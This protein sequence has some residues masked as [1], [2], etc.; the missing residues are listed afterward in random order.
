VI[1][2]TEPACQTVTVTNGLTTT[3]QGNFTQRGFL[4][5]LTTAGTPAT[6]YVEDI[7]RNDWGDWTD[8]PTG[9][10]TVCYGAA[11]GYARPPACVSATV[12]AGATTTITGTYN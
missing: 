8:Y 4:R 6:V 7:P 12:N 11:S 2:W 1:G 9:A 3:V 5:V 10:H